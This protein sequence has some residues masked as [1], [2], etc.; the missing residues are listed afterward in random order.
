VIAPHDIKKGPAYVLSDAG[1]ELFP[2][3]PTDLDVA[4][5]TFCDAVCHGGGHGRRPLPAGD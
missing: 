5:E 1:V 3:D 2:T 4:L